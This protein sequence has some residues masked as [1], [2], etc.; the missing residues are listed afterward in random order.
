MITTELQAMKASI[1]M[2]QETNMAWTPMTLTKLHMQCNRVFSHKKLST[3]SSAKKP[4]IDTNQ[5]GL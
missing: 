1:F 4:M 5:V 2:A 3:S